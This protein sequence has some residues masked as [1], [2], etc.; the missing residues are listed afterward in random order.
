MKTT[1]E[2]FAELV[3]DSTS[4]ADMFRKMGWTTNGTAYRHCKKRVERLAI[5]TSHFKRG[6]P[7]GVRPKKSQVEQLVLGSAGFSV[8]SRDLREGLAQLGR[9]YEC[10]GV[11][12]PCG[13]TGMWQGV[14][15]TLDVD[16]INGIRHD[17]RPE[18]LRFLCK[19][20]HGITDT[21]GVKNMPRRPES[22]CHC[23]KK[24]A[25]RSV[26]CSTC[27][28]SSDKNRKSQPKK[29][30]WPEDQ[31]LR[32]KLAASSYSA[33]ARELGVSDNAIRKHLKNK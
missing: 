12:A 15:L 1:D 24:K 30:D 21:F 4:Y 19:N 13:N 26:E 22:R 18:N 10:V 3:R 31:D 20:C 17:N 29:I 7:S 14:E 33:V 28:T 27:Y 2:G 9:S 6:T 8:K 11:L 25:E 23:G 16:H 5:D 32:D